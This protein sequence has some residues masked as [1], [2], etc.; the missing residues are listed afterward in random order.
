MEPIDVLAERLCD[1]LARFDP[2]LWSGEECAALAERLARVEKAAQAARARASARAGVCGAHRAR[3]F[4]STREWMAA[5]AGTSMRD[6]KTA[7]DAVAAVQRLPDTMDALADGRISLAQADEI[8]KTE[9]AVPGSELELLQLAKDSSL[10]RLRERA[11]RRR[12]DAMDPDDLAAQQH[13]AR[14]AAHWRDTE[15]GMVRV[16][17]ALTPEVGIPFVNRWDAE[18][19]RLWRAARHLGEFPSR[20]AVRRRCARAHARRQWNRTQWSGRCRLRLRCQRG[21]S[22]SCASR[23]D[24]RDPRRRPGTSLDRDGRRTGCVHQVRAARRRGDTACRALRPSSQRAAAHGPD[25]GTTARVRWRDVLR[26][27]L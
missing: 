27:G 6:A 13:S 21:D 18:T 9:A 14:E 26:T 2:E 15:L 11:R 16:S 25:A 20:G 24:L 4:A 5:A 8:A 23:R 1:E 3:G 19:D 22:W 10:G 17:A 7:L 12:V